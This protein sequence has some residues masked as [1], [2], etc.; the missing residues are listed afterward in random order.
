MPHR[1]LVGDL[2]TPALLLDLDVLERNL[3]AMAAKTHALGVRLRPHV[4]THKCPEIGRLQLAAGARG[5]T[6]ATLAEAEAFAAAGFD[7]V[8]WAFPLALSRLAEAVALARRITFRVTLESAAKV[9]RIARAVA[10]FGARM[11]H[12]P[13]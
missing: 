1:R 11:K 10:S 3:A 5:I 9:S 12:W 13:F 6:V 4:K 7:D 2:P 8:T